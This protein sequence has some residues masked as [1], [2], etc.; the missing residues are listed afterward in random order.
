MLAG[1]LT[2]FSIPDVFQ[3]LA[4][5]RKTGLLHLT[6]PDARGRVWIL[7]GSLT[8]AVA[9]IRHAPLAS[10]LLQGGD[11]G[12]DAVEALITAQAA[13]GP[14]AIG[15]TLADAGMAPDRIAQ[16]LRDQVVDAVFE[17]SRWATGDFS[18]EPTTAGADA[19][20]DAPAVPAAEVL[21]AAASRAAEWEGITSQLPSPGSVLTVVARPPVQSGVIQ[22]TPQQWEVLTLVDGTRSVADVIALTGQGQFVVARLLA[23]M[24]ADGLLAVGDAAGEEPRTRSRARLVAD[25]EHRLLGAAPPA[26]TFTPAPAPASPPPPSILLPEPE[27]EVEDEPSIDVNAFLASGSGDDGGDADA[28]DADAPPAEDRQKDDADLL[29]RL[30]DGVKGA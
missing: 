23:G 4:A 2:E 21:D 3:L 6:G 17:L 22:I 19:G 13:D 15:R 12:E 26:P 10:R 25:L 11:I 28:A 9:D 16:V 1:S 30:I 18:F 7:A 29:S 24:V 5:T 27:P 8:Y 14:G 20:V